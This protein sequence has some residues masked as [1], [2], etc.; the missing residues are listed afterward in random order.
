MRLRKYLKK[1]LNLPKKIYSLFKHTK[2]KH[3][4]PEE[5]QVQDSPYVDPLLEQSQ[6]QD[7]PH[8]DP[9]PEGSKLI[10]LI[11]SDGMIVER[12]YLTLDGD[13]ISIKS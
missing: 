2:S 11:V 8:F 12:I 5:S 3:E 6:V 1:G 10:K 7:L 4:K 9:L 13:K